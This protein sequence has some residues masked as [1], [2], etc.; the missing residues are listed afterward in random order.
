MSTSIVVFLLP[1]TNICFLIIIFPS[2]IDIFL[3]FFIQSRLFYLKFFSQS[4]DSRIDNSYGVKMVLSGEDAF[5]N[6]V[7]SLTPVPVDDVNIF[8]FSFISLF[9][10]LMMPIRLKLIPRG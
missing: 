3:Y 8:L 10:Y 6:S 5:F 2:I 9:E 7:K 1:N 4:T